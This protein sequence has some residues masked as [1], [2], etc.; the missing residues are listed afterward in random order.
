MIT[1]I[2]SLCVSGVSPLVTSVETFI[3]PGIREFNIIGLAG[4]SVKE[5]K[6]RVCAAIRNCGFEIP[7]GRITVNL[8]PSDVR[9][10][11]TAFDL[12]I[13]AGILCVG[14]YIDPESL[15]GF[16][17][18]GELSLEG[19]VRPVAGAFSMCAFAMKQGL[20]DI[21]IP[22]DSFKEV[23]CIEGVRFWPVGKLS[24]LTDVSK[25]LKMPLEGRLSDFP[26]QEELC[27]LSDVKGHK[28]A[29]RAIE[30]AVSGGHN[31]LMMGA[32]GSG[33]TMLAHGIRSVLPPLDKE[34]VYDVTSIYSLCGMLSTGDPVITH[35]PFREVH[36]GITKTA[37]IGGGRPVV[38]GEISLAHRGVLFLDEVTE[39]DRCVLDALR[40]P[41]D[42]G[43]ITVSR[44]GHIEK[45][46]SNF[47]LV[48]AMNPCRCGNLLEGPEKCTCT[49]KMISHTLEK[50]SR[51]ML[52]RIDIHIAVKTPGYSELC[53]DVPESA[54]AVRKRITAERAL[55][56]EKIRAAG[57]SGRTYSDLSVEE[58]AQVCE[59]TGSAE[60]I[61]LHFAESLSLSIRAF[62]KLKALSLTVADMNG[63]SAVRD[64]D[65]G[66]AVQYRIID[67]K[68]FSEGGY[69][70]NAA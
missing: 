28:T 20:T 44:V 2:N 26:R 7:R 55:Q 66:E 69:A 22:E 47:M 37:L 32:A 12:A 49:P 42:S 10:E 13:A 60:K 38:P 6:N 70:D 19:N 54:E 31:I 1:K 27:T 41:M 14:G 53:S 64:D 62:N 46:P 21:V 35:A 39:I 17:L 11:G 9:K 25:R 68:L 34:D 24:E 57:L 48:C 4:T 45:L 43:E 40:Q 52:D 18:I 8:A 30:I 36:T 63:H 15:R 61:L 16:A 50:L 51:P 3:T 58:L 23:S 33:K 56:K 59:M 29:R 67:R 65:I 5:S